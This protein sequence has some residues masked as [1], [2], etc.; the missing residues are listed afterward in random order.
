MREAHGSMELQHLRT[1]VAIVEAGGV[2]RA[3]A[4]LNLSQ[5]ALSRQIRSLEDELGIRLFDRIGRRI[6]LTSEGEDLL[7]RGRRLLTDATSL[8]ERARALKTGE[9]GVLRV[10]ATPQVIENVLARFLPRYRKRHPGVEVHLVEE[11]GRQLH[12]CLDRGEF[13]VGVMTAGD[14]RF[15]GHPLFP[16]ACLAVMARS[17]RLSRRAT[18]D[19]TQLAEEPV[20]LLRRGF[21]SRAAF[22]DACRIAHIAPP[23]LL[24]SAAPHSLIAL[25][26]AGYGVAVI[27]SPVL[28][29]AA[30]L[31]RS[32]ARAVPLVQGKR[33]VGGWVGVA[34]DPRRFRAPYAERFVEELTAY[35]R[36]AYP[37]RGFIPHAP[38]IPRP[39]AAPAAG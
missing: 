6:Q 9:T 3:A 21:G 8:A 39:P 23:L 5:P 30:Q 22:D 31:R 37:G 36:H 19:I 29:S 38:P 11:G 25:A 12:E 27:P 15:H 20:L 34:W 10:G 4:R 32:G 1:F 28:L 13:H 33:T 17:H 7:H 24:E 18:V 2:G 14:P 26:R 35:V 16:W